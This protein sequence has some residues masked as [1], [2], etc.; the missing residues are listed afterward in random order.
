MS[1]FLRPR[2][3]IGLPLVVAATIVLTATIGLTFH[4]ESV[5]RER[6]VARGLL[7]DGLWQS[8]VTALG[9]KT[10]R[11]GDELVADVSVL[12]LLVWLGSFSLVAWLG[13]AVLIARRR[14]IPFQ[15][16]LI[17]WG[18]G[19]WLWWLL[20]VLW[21]LPGTA[22]DF[23]DAGECRIL[24]QQLLPPVHCALW[25]GWCTTFFA[26]ARGDLSRTGATDEDPRV[27]A[28]VWGGIAAYFLCFG[29]MNW[30]LYESLLVP[31][32]DSAMYEEHIWNLLHGKGFRSYLD[33]GRLFLG[34]HIQVIHLFVIPVYLLWPS[35][36][37]LEL[38]QSAGLAVGAVPVFRI[39]QRHSRST[40]A[41]TLLAL[42]YLL[43][44][45]MQFLDIAITFKTFRPNSF[46]IPFL[47][48]GLDALE[49]SRYR[50]LL[51]WLGLTLLCQEDAATVIAPLGIWIAFRQARCAA[52]TPA[53]A[54]QPRDS[55]VPFRLLLFG[56]GM[57]LFGAAY[58][59]VVIKFVLPW[60]RSGADVHFAQYFHDLGATSGEI[61][62][63][64]VMHPGVVAGHLFGAASATFALHLVAPVGFL[65][66]L[67]P[68]RLTVALPLFAVL[69]L[70][71][72]TNSP[73]HHFH[74][75]LVPIVFWAAAAGLARASIVFEA[76]TA[77]RRRR[78]GN[79]AGEPERR[80]IP[81]EKFV[82]SGKLLSGD[83]VPA[84][85][86]KGL[87]APSMALNPSVV[88]VAALWAFLNALLNG[89]PV[90]FS[91]LGFGFWDPHSRGY[92]RNLY[93]PGERAQRFPAAIALVPFDARV[94]STDYIHPRFTHHTRSYD[95]SDYRPH[96]PEDCDYIV[97][98]TRHPYSEISRPEQLKEY[99]DH[100][101]QWELL[102][103]RT[104]GYFIVLKRKRHD[105]GSTNTAAAS[106]YR[107]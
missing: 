107:R 85:A 79:A 98:D 88:V 81:A 52:C 61:V 106:E 16:A 46:E 82:P 51:I 63:N 5:L 22:A 19:G 41:A 101:N 93:V 12:R 104:E 62:H 50:T 43:Y 73:F 56:L 26:L 30:M 65:P 32:G 66:L 42:T 74:A 102:D 33:N 96:V 47:L 4:V 54:E 35:H 97:I 34:E 44:F 29:V 45:P 6:I 3:T 105:A 103:D 9:G 10:I 67:S 1:A 80:R 94:A 84:T 69:C 60:F 87:P 53:I 36:V 57:A 68:G 92:W 99:R 71:A 91:P 14:K 70:S 89:L 17:Q 55:W 75:P 21:E 39:A 2:R 24:W 95:Y 28:V 76:A 64:V 23:L 78:S 15:A 59:V 100:P 83:L 25:A 31:H 48:F 90:T 7:G 72:I 49:R 27:P 20:P 11:H 58:V 8:I 18:R 37:L 86:P 38:C 40:A 77:W 13:G